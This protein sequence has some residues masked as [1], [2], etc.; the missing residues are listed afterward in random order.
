MAWVEER[1]FK[2]VGEVEYAFYNAPIVPGFLR[3]NEVWIA[4]EPV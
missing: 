1:G 2:P 4:V 3:R